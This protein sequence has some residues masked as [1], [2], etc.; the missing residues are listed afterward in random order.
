ME[1][2]ISRARARMLVASFQQKHLV[3]VG[4]LMLDEFLLGDVTRI[5]PEAPVPVLD[6][7][8][9]RH[10]P[11]G[12]ANAAANIVSLGGRATIVG[13]VGADA[14]GETLRAEMGR[15]GIETTALTV[16]PGRPTTQKLRIVA[17]TQQIVRVDL[18]R[19]DPLD[20]QREQELVERL[21]HAVVAADGI[22]VSDYA[23]GVVTEGV[24]RACV[25]LAAKRGI[26]LVVDPKVR[27]FSR[28]AGAT[29]ITPNVLELEYATGLQTHNR[30]EEVVAA[31]RSLLPRLGGAALLVTR[32]AAGM[33]LVPAA[34]PPVHLPT[35]ARAVF[36]VTGAGDSV[37][38]ALALAL[39]AA[40]SLADAL[41]LST[42]AASC[43]VARPGTVSVTAEELIASFGE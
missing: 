14:Q 34:G 22:V 29:I 8:E 21:E 3:V 26:P 7:T 6:L 30:D 20:P 35:V 5:S 16:D 38:S 25:A 36:D 23:K 37:V 4:D 27:D 41:A 42:R 43:A 10:T 33:T 12:A 9:R 18:E 19:R 28:Y 17:R 11:G 32:G 31:A 40:V 1:T 13:V 15:A 39:A 24:L 2:L